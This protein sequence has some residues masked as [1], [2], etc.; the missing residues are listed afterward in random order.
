MPQ[1]V[2]ESHVILTI[3]MVPSG[4]CLWRKG[5]HGVICR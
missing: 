4:E 1:N 5:R 3:L 2:T